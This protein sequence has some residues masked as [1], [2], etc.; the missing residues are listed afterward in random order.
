MTDRTDIGQ[1]VITVITEVLQEEGVSSPEVNGGD[2]LTAIGVSS[3]VFARVT[4]DL[5]DQLGVDP[6]GGGLPTGT[7]RTVDDLVEAYVVATGEK[8]RS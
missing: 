5:E 1:V 2:S 7:V 3:L 6:F 8:G 4:I